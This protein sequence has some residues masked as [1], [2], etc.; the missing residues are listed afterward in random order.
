MKKQAP[1]THTCSQVENLKRIAD[2]GRELH[3]AINGNGKKGIRE[4]VSNLSE[5]METVIKDNE[6]IKADLKVLVQFQTQV[7]TKEEEREKHKNEIVAIK[8]TSSG[9][10]RWLIGLIISTSLTLMGLII[11]IIT[12]INKM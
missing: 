1:E 8:K 7:E 5:K 3:H 2:Q 11:T 12:L 9:R 4:I 10:N 6:A